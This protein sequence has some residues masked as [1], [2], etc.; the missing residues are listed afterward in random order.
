MIL[1]Y[2]TQTLLRLGVYRYRIRRTRV[3]S[4]TLFIYNNTVFVCYVNTVSASQCCV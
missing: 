2:E 1:H 3:T 4:T